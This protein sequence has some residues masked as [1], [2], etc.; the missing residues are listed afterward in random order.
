[1]RHR[2]RRSSRNEE[3]LTWLHARTHTRTH[4]QRTEARPRARARDETHARTSTYTYTMH[5]ETYISRGDEYRIPRIK[6]T[7][8]RLA[9]SRAARY[10][11]S[12][13]GGYDDDD[14][15]RRS[16]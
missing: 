14:D 9:V 2:R 15:E 5:R 7:K 8:V 3:G 1:M 6:A 12:T 4:I 10:R 16:R 13:A 11:R